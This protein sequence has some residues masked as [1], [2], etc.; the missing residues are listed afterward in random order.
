MR[1]Q[2]HLEMV[3]A[4][5]LLHLHHDGLAGQG[6]GPHGLLVGTGGDVQSV[7]LEN[8]SVKYLKIFHNKY[9]YRAALNKITIN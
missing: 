6:Q 1:A 3:G 4:V 5:P 7:H 8:I 2:P 9:H